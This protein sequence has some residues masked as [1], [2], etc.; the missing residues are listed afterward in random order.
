MSAPSME[1]ENLQKA[2]DVAE[3][4]KAVRRIIAAYDPR[5][6]S[7]KLKIFLRAGSGISPVQYSTDTVLPVLRAHE[8]AYENELYKLGVKYGPS[9]ENPWEK[10]KEIYHR[11]S[12]EIQMHPDFKNYLE[13]IRTGKK[14][15]TNKFENETAIRAC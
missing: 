8:Q 2:A 4:L 6:C 7:A 15:F 5:D 3:K 11:I 10:R 13:A 9:A 14:E 12:L 1:L